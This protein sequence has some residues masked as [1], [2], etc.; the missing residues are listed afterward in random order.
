MRIEWSLDAIRD[1]DRIQDYL[2]ER[3]PQA[4]ERIW[5]RIHER[6]GLQAHIPFA[7]P[8]YAEGPARML[9]I[10]GTPYLVFYVL[11]DDVLRVEQVLHGA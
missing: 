10:T 4:A 9:V 8:I 3:N 5:L 11:D 1:L 6:V 7:A 2:I